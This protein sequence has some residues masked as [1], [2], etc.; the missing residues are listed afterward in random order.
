[1]S[2]FL[3]INADIWTVIVMGV[4][5]VLALLMIFRRGDIP[6]A[7]VAIWALV[8]IYMRSFETA[9]YDVLADQNIA[10]VN[11]A[12]LGLSL[13]IAAAIVVYLFTHRG[14]VAARTPIR[15]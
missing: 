3:G 1:V 9:V 14:E 13:L 2:G 15:T 8:G 4:A 7:L 11:N 5:T 10:L 12:A 6:Y